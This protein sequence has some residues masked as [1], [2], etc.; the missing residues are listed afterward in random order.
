MK[1]QYITGSNRGRNV[2]ELGKVFHSSQFSQEIATFW[3]V[4]SPWF[5]EE[6]VLDED[7]DDEHDHSL[8]GHGAKVLSHHSP[9]EWILET[10]FP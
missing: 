6:L 7:C 4:H 3:H 2:E 5:A 1:M 8:D 10:V 9:A